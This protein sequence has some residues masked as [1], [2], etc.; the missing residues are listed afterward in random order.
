MT[1]T[2]GCYA[3][4]LERRQV[5]RQADRQADRQKTGNETKPKLT[6]LIRCASSPAARTL[7]TRP[8]QDPTLLKRA[9]MLLERSEIL[10]QRLKP[11]I[12]PLKIR[13]LF[14]RLAELSHDIAHGA[15]VVVE[16][17]GGFHGGD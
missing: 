2:P 13:I 8:P 6:R 12:L 10:L 16:A 9:H 11:R 15:G 14:Q 7:L 1:R 5:G 3:E 17:V 4:S